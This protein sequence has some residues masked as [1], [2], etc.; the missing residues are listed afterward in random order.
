[1][2]VLGIRSLRNVAAQAR[3]LGILLG[4]KN[5]V[6]LEMRFQMHHPQLRLQLANSRQRRRLAIAE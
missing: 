5:E 6:L 3:V 1:M 4:R 2:R